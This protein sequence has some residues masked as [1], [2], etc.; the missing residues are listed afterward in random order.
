MGAMTTMPKGLMVAAGGS[1]VSNVLTFAT[2]VMFIAY[3]LWR[4]RAYRR[5]YWPR[6][7]PPRA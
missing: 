1:V 4:F 3:G 5:R 7:R 6:N 2:A